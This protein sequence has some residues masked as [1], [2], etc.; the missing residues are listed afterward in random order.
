MS[1]RVEAVEEAY[2]K[3][4]TVKVENVFQNVVLSKDLNVNQKIEVNTLF[5]V[6][7]IV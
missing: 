5:R 3:S 2:K 7:S 6:D 1:A 4:H